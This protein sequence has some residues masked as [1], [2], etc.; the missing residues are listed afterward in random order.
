MSDCWGGVFGKYPLAGDFVTR[1]L[2][3]GLKRPL[4]RWITQNLATRETGW[5]TGGMRGVLGLGGTKTLLLALQSHDKTG[6][7]FPLVALA[8]PPSTRAEADKWCETVLPALTAAVS[9]EMDIDALLATASEAA[10]ASALSMPPTFWS[11][12]S[13]PTALVGALF[14]DA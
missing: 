13:E 12:E 10:P 14:E 1:G 3:I 2:P 11:A 9:G 8:S 7:S 6:R 4:D 5:P